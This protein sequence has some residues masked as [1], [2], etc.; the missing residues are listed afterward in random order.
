MEITKDIRNYLGNEAQAMN[1]ERDFPEFYAANKEGIDSGDIVGYWD[2][3]ASEAGVLIE[4][5]TG[6]VVSYDARA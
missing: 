5:S 3:W 4:K 6:K 2:P 1:F